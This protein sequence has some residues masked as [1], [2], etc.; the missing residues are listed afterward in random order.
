MRRVQDVVACCVASVKAH[1]RLAR[2]RPLEFVCVRL[3]D[4][5]RP[6]LSSVRL[7]ACEHVCFC[8]PERVAL[9][10]L[11]FDERCCSVLEPRRRSR[12]RRSQPIHRLFVVVASSPPSSPRPSLAP[13]SIAQCALIKRQSVEQSAEFPRESGLCDLDADRRPHCPQQQSLGGNPS[14]SACRTQLICTAVLEDSPH[15]YVTRVDV[16]LELVSAWL[17]CA[18]VFEMKTLRTCRA[19]K[20]P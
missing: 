8:S 10:L 12:F 7:L 19:G 20:I 4:E 14:R 3:L 2:S 11:C 9:R 18:I 16:S 1:Q 15:C 5:S 6:D 17:S 13:T